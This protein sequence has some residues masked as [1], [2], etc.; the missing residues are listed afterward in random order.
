MAFSGKT[1]ESLGEENGREVMVRKRAE[2]LQGEG[3]NEGT[4]AK[5]RLIYGLNL[6]IV[7]FFCRDSL[8]PTQL[9]IT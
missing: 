5:E 8:N 3:Q 9:P 4:I 1:W 6:S 2:K 7:P